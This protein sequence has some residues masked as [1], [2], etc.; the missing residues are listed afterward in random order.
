MADDRVFHW[1][2]LAPGETCLGR[3]WRVAR[4]GEC[5]GEMWAVGR[6]PI[7]GTRGA[8]ALAWW[9]GEPHGETGNLGSR[10][11][12]M[13]GARSKSVGLLVGLPRGGDRE[14]EWHAM[15][16]WMGD[17]VGVVSNRAS[18]D[19]KA[20]HEALGTMPRP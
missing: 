20:A 15:G 17:A 3:A 1:S 12:K 9:R 6:F 5:G 16:D 14:G 7:G 10:A 8:E 18:I 4:V 11:A 2:C 19:P 13:L